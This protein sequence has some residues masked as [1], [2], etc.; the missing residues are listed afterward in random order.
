MISATARSVASELDRYG[1]ADTARW[2]LTCSEDELVRIGSV[3]FW[4]S[5]AAAT[6]RGSESVSDQKALCLAAVYVKEGRPRDLALKR[7][8]SSSL[9]DEQR[10]GLNG[11]PRTGDRRV[12]FPKDY[13]VG[14]DLR[15]FWGAAVDASTVTSGLV[16]A[17]VPHDKPTIER[18][19]MEI[20]YDRWGQSRR[21]FP[22]LASPGNP[23]ASGNA[24]T[25]LDGTRKWSTVWAK[26]PPGVAVADLSED[27]PEEYLQVAG[28]RGRLVFECR[29]FVDGRYRQYA[30]GRSGAAESEALSEEVQWS[31]YVLR[32]KPSEV[33][34]SAR[35]TPIF[36]Y[37]FDHG[38]LPDGLSERELHL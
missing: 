27:W 19:H 32:V 22:T 12:R 21:T 20:T 17:G 36:K 8:R 33:W 31:D 16:T 34:T 15:R 30:M 1:E 2:I 3:G 6:R 38:V 35:V 14:D 10:R 5:G 37:W 4:I 13:G 18:T 25:Y 26:L 28:Q 23:F 9:T 24:F 29:R 11:G 7:R